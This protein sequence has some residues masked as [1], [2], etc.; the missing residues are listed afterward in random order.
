[1][2]KHES[3]RKLQDADIR[4]ITKN[5]QEINENKKLTMKHNVAN[6]CSTIVDRQKDQHIGRQ[7]DG[8]TDTQTD[9]H[10]D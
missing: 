6:K 3:I 2:E 4:T 8:Q 10:T 9:K 7:T 5:K 1:M